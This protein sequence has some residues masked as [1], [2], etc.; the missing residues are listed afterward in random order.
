MA[1][2]WF[3]LA[4][5]ITTDMYKLVRTSI[6]QA[7]PI[8]TGLAFYAMLSPGIIIWEVSTYGCK[9]ELT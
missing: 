3:I 7:E 4:T 2:F 6:D 8:L 9:C 5:F 1:L